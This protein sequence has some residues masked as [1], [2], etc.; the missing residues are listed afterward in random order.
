[1]TETRIEKGKN[2]AC[3]IFAGLSAAFALLP[4]LILIPSVLNEG[5]MNF[6][7]AFTAYVIMSIAG[8][9]V[10]VLFRLPF[11]AGTSLIMTY[12][13]VYLGIVAN[14][15]TWN[16]LLGISLVVSLLGTVLCLVP[17][18]RRFGEL[19]PA[20][21]RKSLP[22]GVGVMLIWLGFV[23][24]HIILASPWSVTMLG[25]FQDPLAYL[26]LIGI[27]LTVGMLARGWKF[28]LLLGGVVTAIIALNEGFWA[29][30]NEDWLD[31]EGL[32]KVAGFLDVWAVHDS[33][34]P[35]MFMTGLTMLL[36]L[37]CVNVGT[38]SSSQEEK[39]KKV[40]AS[41]FALSA[42]GSFI[43]ALP[44]TASPLSAFSANLA[45]HSRCAAGIAAILL[46]LAL[47]MEPVLAAMADFPVMTVPVLVGGGIIL[48][49]QTLRVLSKEKQQWGQIESLLPALC[50]VLLMPLSMNVAAGIGTGI[51]SYVLIQTA[52]G[53]GRQIPLGTWL[54]A[55]LFA[56]YFVYGTI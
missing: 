30:P 49:A 1:M 37:M 9:L 21:V 28:S 26:G 19:L 41:L 8:T 3:D 32:D 31:P 27:V 40:M 55:L 34:Y 33:Q 50:V 6:K 36:F 17:W 13:L 44:M 23:Q 29:W 51:L 52:K 4:G 10:L 11:V 14:G 45:K 48:I 12:Y 46:L 54:T 53:N 56:C 47:Y 24:G 35:I 2:W 22:L 39:P 38:L 25:N 43:G 5:G 15:L 20:P 18:G 16:Q 7:G 42:V